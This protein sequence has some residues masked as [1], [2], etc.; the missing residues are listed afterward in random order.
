MKFSS[1]KFR[2]LHLHG[3]ARFRDG[4][5]VTDDPAIADRVLHVGAPYGVTAL[6]DDSGSPF[7]PSAASAKAVN[8]YLTAASPAERARVVGAERAGKNRPTALK[9]FDEPE[10]APVEETSGESDTRPSSLAPPPVE[11]ELRPEGAPPPV[12]LADPAGGDADVQLD[13]ASAPAGDPEV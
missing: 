9:G 13:G 5:F 11:G 12:E 6:K 7:D 8:A 2:R 4:V 10:S 1:P 3:I